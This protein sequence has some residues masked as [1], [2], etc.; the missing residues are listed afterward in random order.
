[1][2]KAQKG[3]LS[4]EDEQPADNG[5]GGAVQESTASAGSAQISKKMKR[6]QKTTKRGL[7]DRDNVSSSS[8]VD[9]PSNRNSKKTKRIPRQNRD[10]DYDYN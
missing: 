8:A 5:L 2:K 6:T 1:M 9:D 3:L 7:P 4:S 10:L